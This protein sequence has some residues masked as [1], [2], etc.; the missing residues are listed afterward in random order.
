MWLETKEVACKA[1]SQNKGKISLVSLVAT[2][3]EPFVCCDRETTV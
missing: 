2:S 3:Y 1:T